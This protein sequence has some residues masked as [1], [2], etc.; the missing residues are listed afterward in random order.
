[1]SET[2]QLQV[3]TNGAWKTVICFEDA[4]P[5]DNFEDVQL[6]AQHL[7]RAE[8]RAAFRIATCEGVPQALHRLDAR[9]TNGLWKAV[10]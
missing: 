10:E 4:E 9:T 8:P 1:M 7:L 6:A 3:N 2:L 5:G